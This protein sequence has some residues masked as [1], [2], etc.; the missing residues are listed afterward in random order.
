MNQWAARRKIIIFGIV[1]LAL[2]LIVGIPAFLVSRD[3]PDCANGVLDGD[4]TGV[5]CGGSCQLICTPEVLPLITRGDARLLKIASST[6]EIVVVVENPNINGEVVRA[7]YA[8][9]VYSSASRNPLK[10]FEKET[11]IG[12]NSTFALFEGPFTLEGEGPFRV[13]F[14]WGENLSWKKSD[15]A[16][17]IIAVENMNLIVSSSTSPR[18][19]ARL[20]NRS[21]REERNIEAIALLTDASGNIV[22]AGKTFVDSLPRA[23]S[24]PIV[25]SWPDAFDPEPVSIRII[26]HVL[27]DKSYLR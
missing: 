13:V 18:L 1:A 3:K 9:A 5:D 19:E 17:P 22:A 20:S 25:F 15:T 21:E 12:R 10:V 6:Y 27:P 2:L 7:P 4:E 24:V 8:F 16:K 14:E 26:P 11:Y 23:S